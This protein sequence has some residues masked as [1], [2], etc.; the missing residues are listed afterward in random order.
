MDIG[1]LR[2]RQGG[3]SRS[4]K[5]GEEGG[6]GEEA[7]NTHSGPASI[8]ERH[9]GGVEKIVQAAWQST[10]VGVGAGRI[11]PLRSYAHT[12]A[13]IL[14]W[15]WN[16]GLSCLDN[17]RARN[18]PVHNSRAR[19]LRWM[20]VAAAGPGDLRR[21]PALDPPGGFARGPSVVPWRLFP[22]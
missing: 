13:H 11:H 15:C 18:S 1:T 8:H 6:E 3:R 5:V 20:A 14:H 7:R 16:R 9:E 17:P 12:L 22:P 10:G 2:T 19:D 21:L 4:W